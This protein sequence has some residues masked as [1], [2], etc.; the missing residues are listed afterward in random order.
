M[1]ILYKSFKNVLKMILAG[2]VMTTSV[3]GV[4][5]QTFDV[6]IGTQT[7]T[8]TTIPISSYYEYSY[9]QQIY[10]VADLN[11]AGINGIAKITSIR[12]YKTTGSMSD[13]Y[14]W[15]VYLGNTE[16]TSFTSDS[17]WEVISNLEQ[18]Y[19]GI[20][21]DAGSNAWYE[22]T[23]DTPFIWDGTSNLIVAVDENQPD[24][25]ANTYWHKSDLGSNRS[26]Y[27]RSDSNNP[28]PSSP[29]TASGRNGYVN[30]IQLVVTTPSPCDG[31]A[32]LTDILSDAGTDVC[33]NSNMVLSL[34]NGLALYFLDGITYQWQQFDGTNW[35]DIA[36][37]DESTYAIASILESGDYQVVIGC[38]HTG[39]EVTLSPLSITVHEAPAV[40]VDIAESAVC[41]STAVTVTA[42]GADTYSWVPSV[43]LSAVNTAS[44]DALPTAKTTYTVTGT[45][46]HGCTATAQTTITP[47]AAIAPKAIVNPSELCSAN[48]PVS[49]TVDQTPEV[50][51]GT[52]EY[53]FLDAEGETEI[54]P[55]NTTNAYNFIPAEDGVY[56][57]YYQLRNSACTNTLDSTAVSIVV[58]FGGDIIT[59]PYDCNNLGGSIA[60]ENTFGQVDITSIY[61]NDFNAPADLSAFTLSGQAANV[62]GRL[63]LTPSS[64]SI[65]GYASLS[66]PGFVSGANNSFGLSFDLTADQPVGTFGTGGADGVAYSFGDDAAPTSNGTGHNGR[67]TKLRLS[68]DSA[69]NGTE[70]GN[71]PGIYLVYGWTSN[72]AFGPGN[73]QTL[74]Y[75][76]NTALWKGKTDVPV[77]FEIDANGLAHLT[78]DGVS[79]FSNIQMPPAYL[80]SDVSGWKHLF[81]AQTGG[82]GMRHA[83]DNLNIESGTL[84]FGITQNPT[85][86]PE[87]WQVT[88]T[89]T[90]LM[91][92]T[93]YVW[94]AKN[95]TAA[96]GKQIEMVVIENLNPVVN[97]GA[98][99][100]IC[101]GETLTLDAGN[102]GSVYIWSNSN[103]TGQTLDISAAGTYT[104][105]A[106]A[107]NG[108]L[109][110]GNINIYVNDVP[111]ATGI[112]RQGT[113][114]NFTFTVLNAQNAHTYDWDF[115]DGTVLTNAPATVQHHFTGSASTT[116]TATLSN[117]CGAIDVSAVYND[118]SVENTQLSG[119]T[120]YPN[121][122]TDK[123]TVALDNA[124]EA[125]VS[126][127]ATTGAV[128]MENTSFSNQLVVSTTAWEKGIY[129][130]TVATEEHTAT[131]KVVVK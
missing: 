54:Q 2:V 44:V 1:K 45:D 33:Q 7:G 83:I 90:D 110:I 34:D 88:S 67:G 71:A 6:Q 95:E 63:V 18:V 80:N 14:G 42:S 78:V 26:I 59:T 36:D 55:W 102:P 127:V 16:K 111:E 130:V 94:G 5:A 51:G 75:S 11:A 100:T 91:P 115:G 103:E 82:D 43:G 93:Y 86:A 81:S 112:Y 116:V 99:T 79:I 23:F 119:L 52:W 60:L 10:T 96:C 72:T 118:L 20:I 64:T 56:T 117:G 8:A 97:L 106:T 62:D 32:P 74:A 30:N 84:Q 19:S 4:F 53:R 101:E 13:S 126:V 69:S 123:F 131:T 76:N 39:D 108:C 92:G 17:D 3:S 125:S 85:E 12:F 65:N 29:P 50:V 104:V 35:V 25:S 113:Y 21:T 124:S 114:P 58:G 57:F 66:V 47:F 129:F 105:Y 128:V 37:A 38:A 9:S 109:G 28:N 48:V 27:Y 40:A 31:I 73:S 89:F 49:I 24:Y 122:A 41:P 22:I 98:D 68:F 107:P 121:P 70:N 15:D 61:S 46:A 87:N 120:V 77:A